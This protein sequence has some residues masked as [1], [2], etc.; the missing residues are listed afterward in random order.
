MLKFIYWV[1][2]KCKNFSQGNEEKILSEIFKNQQYGYYIDIG[3]HHPFRYSNTAMLYRK[4]WSGINIEG[5]KHNIRLFKYFR[6][7]DINLNCV[8]SNIKNP[9]TFYYF[10]ESALNGILSENRLKSLKKNGF[11]PTNKEKITP[12]TLDKVLE[13]HL[14]KGKRIDL[15]TLDV[16]GH[17]FQVL[18]SLD[19]GK[20][21]IKIILTEAN[22][23]K[24]PLN[25]YLL[26]NGYHLFKT[27][28]RNLFYI[29]GKL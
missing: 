2:Y 19:L 8:I 11:M 20:Y 27:E 9:V 14:P 5:S 22:E 26:K 29:K 4:G 21:Y 3:A 18:K 15:L 10:K 1:I 24:I 17:D 7:R 16:E 6:K 13:L 23:N 25:Q 12:L 28:D